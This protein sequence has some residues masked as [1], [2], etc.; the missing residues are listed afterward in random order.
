MKIKTKKA[1][2]SYLFDFKIEKINKKFTKK[3]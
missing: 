3:I 1:A 2:R